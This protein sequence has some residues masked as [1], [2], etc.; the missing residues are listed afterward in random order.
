MDPQ[1]TYPLTL[2]NDVMEM[3]EKQKKEM[4]FQTTAIDPTFGMKWALCCSKVT[5]C[6]CEMAEPIRKV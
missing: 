5:N 2:T 3:I 4:T 6:T 1:E